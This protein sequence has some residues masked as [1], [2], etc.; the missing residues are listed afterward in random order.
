MWM[1]QKTTG[2]S[3]IKVYQVGNLYFVEDGHHRVSVARQLGLKLIEAEIWECQ[4]RS[5][6][7]YP[8]SVKNALAYKLR[9]EYHVM[10]RHVLQEEGTMENTN[11]V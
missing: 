1:L 9:K 3:S 6:L 5:H 7:P 4:I 8:G 10:A 11:D 2:W